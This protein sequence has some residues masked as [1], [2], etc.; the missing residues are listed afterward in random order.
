MEA[1]VGGPAWMAGM[2]LVGVCLKAAEQ[3]GDS[4]GPE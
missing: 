2:G 4:G 1:G 3:G